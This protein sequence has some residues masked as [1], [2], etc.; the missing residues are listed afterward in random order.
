MDFLLLTVSM[1][2]EKQ[3]ANFIAV[4]NSCICLMEHLLKYR[5][6]LIMDRLPPYL[7]QY[8]LLLQKLCYQSSSK[9]TLHENEVQQISDCA[10]KLEKI[11]R[12]LVECTKDMSR[13]ALYL[14]ADILS[15]YEEDIAYPTVKVRFINLMNQI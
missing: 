4:F 6:P 14:I 7:L 3:P 10:H 12:S 2:M 8:R 11:T 15:C 5:N 13:I 1:L 9:V